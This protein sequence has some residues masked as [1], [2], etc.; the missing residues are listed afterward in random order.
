[1][2]KCTFWD[3]LTTYNKYD[4]SKTAHQDVVNTLNKHGHHTKMSDAW[5]S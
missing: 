3:V 5:C 4:G 1:M 2:G